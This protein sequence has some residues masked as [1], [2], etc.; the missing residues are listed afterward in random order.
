MSIADQHRHRHRLAQRAAQTQNDGAEDAGAGVRH[1]GRDHRLPPGGAERQGRLALRVGN[2]HEHL[3][4]TDM[5]YGITM[6][7]RMMP[8]AS[9]EGP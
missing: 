4:G 7:A 6:M 8:A 2:G 5:T 1:H 3:A 9:I